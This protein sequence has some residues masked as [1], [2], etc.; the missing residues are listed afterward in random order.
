MAGVFP[1][2]GFGIDSFIEVTSGTTLLWRMSHDTDLER[3][4]RAEHL[5][6]LIVGPCFLAR[7]KR[8]LPADWAAPQ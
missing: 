4:E 3:R 1:L 2:V 8:R 6:L 5:D 7:A